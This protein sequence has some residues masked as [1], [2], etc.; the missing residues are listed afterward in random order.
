MS[1]ATEADAQEFGR[2]PSFIA[3]VLPVL[4]LLLAY[5]DP[6]IQGFEHLPP[7]GPM[8]IAS[9]HSGGIYMPDYWAFV[10]HW[11]RE[12]GPEEPLYSM[13]YD[14]LFSLPG[15]STLARRFGS[16]PANQ[17]NAAH[18]LEE[19]HPVLV[20]PGGDQEDYR[21]WTERHRVDLR[22]RTG[23]VRLALRRQAPVIPLVAHGS[24]DAI[25]VLSRGEAL[26]HG[27]GIDRRLRVKVLPL[28]AG[29]PWGVTIPVIP[30]VPLP[31]KVT[32]RVCEPL[33]WSRYGT[34]A[35]NDPAVVRHCY[36]ELLGRMQSNLD[37]LVA[38]EPHPVLARL[39]D[40][41]RRGSLMRHDRA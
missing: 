10:R 4:D 15:I 17:E 33:D 32:I 37:E 29:F 30:T 26:A 5:F 12:R 25:F 36:E 40:P 39:R 38:A 11:V 18:L 9:N 8:L 20:Y 31:A 23:F 27:I 14:L 28:I 1:L 13:A 24:H 34:E 6:E 21:P 7:A 16:V 3:R 35:A 41:A 2:D 19:G 22:G